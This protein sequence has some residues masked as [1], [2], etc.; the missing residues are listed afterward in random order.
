MR[1]SIRNVWYEPYCKTGKCVHKISTAPPLQLEC[2]SSKEY[3]MNTISAFLRT[4]HVG[5]KTRFFKEHS[6][7]LSRTLLF[8]LDSNNTIH[9][10]VRTQHLKQHPTNYA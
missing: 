5:L 4:W 3:I 8:A 10:N 6:F 9:L 7:S 1:N 2:I